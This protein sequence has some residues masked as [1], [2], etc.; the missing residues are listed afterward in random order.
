MSAIVSDTHSL[1]WYLNDS[2]KL[3]A[4]ALAAFEKAE[5]DG[6]PIYVPAI[7]LVEIRYLVEK[8]KDIFESDFRLIV[9]ELN[10]PISA[11][12]F[13]PINQQLLKISDIF[14]AP[15]CRICPTE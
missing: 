11:L 14:R 7:V 13:A 1:L 2:A 4:D 9:S 12:T 5:T 3:S 8:G 15:M 10:N 6:Q